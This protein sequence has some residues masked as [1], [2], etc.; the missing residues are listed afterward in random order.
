MNVRFDVRTRSCSRFK[1][2]NSSNPCCFLPDNLVKQQHKY[3]VNKSENNFNLK[4]ISKN[5]V[6]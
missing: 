2:A 3:R 1:A 6:I 5:I 4:I